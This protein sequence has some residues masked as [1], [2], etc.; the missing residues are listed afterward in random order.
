MFERLRTLGW[1]I[2]LWLLAVAGI[3]LAIPLAQAHIGKLV[4]LPEALYVV[5][6]IAGAALGAVALLGIA[7]LLIDL[8]LGR[9]R[10]WCE[11]RSVSRRNVQPVFELMRRFFG[12]ETPT[13]SRIL[14]WQSRNKTVLTAIYLKSL[15][16]GRKRQT[17][18]GVYKVVPLTIQAVALLESE[19]KTGT[20]LNPRDIAAETDDPAGL[21]IG[22]VVA[23]T[24]KA[25]GEVI[26]QLKNSLKKQLRPGIFVYTRPLTSD[27]TRLVRQ[28]NFVPIIDGV[29]PG[30]IGRMHKLP[31]EHARRFLN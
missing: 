13:I 4:T 15:R 26:R 21:Y 12:D 24:N 28:Y 20:T 19:R 10:T 25:K 11:C 2:L 31:E 9:R 16:G 22:D 5:L 3:L 30:S 6:A 29:P 17:L 14:A 7:A 8:A 23:L 18:V 1:D 27:G